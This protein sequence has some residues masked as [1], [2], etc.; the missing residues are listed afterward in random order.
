MRT[1]QK[2]QG[3]DQ[4]GLAVYATWSLS[5][6]KLG[7]PARTF[8][9]ISSL[10]HHEGIS[11]EIFKRA[12]S[13]QEELNDSELQRDITRVLELLGKE[14]SQWKTLVFRAVISEL[15]S[16]SLIEFD[17][18]N[19]SYTIHPLVQH[20]SYTTMDNNQHLLKKSTISII[21][22]SISETLTVDDYRFQRTLVPHIVNCTASVIPEEIDL[23]IAEKLASAYGEQGQWKSAEALELMVMDKRMQ[24]L[25][26]EH[27]DTLQ[28]IANLADTYHDL[29]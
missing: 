3:Q 12:A 27:P 17:C 28:S 7:L 13:S 21:G 16:Y 10:L 23:G 8:L 11:E 24:L 25:G 4:Y 18:Q 9:Q 1:S 15:Q 14:G 29:G 6:A 2:G 22:L 26:D 5:Y 19:H 20:W